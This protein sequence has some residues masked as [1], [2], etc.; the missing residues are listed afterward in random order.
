MP[1]RPPRTIHHK[2]TPSAIDNEPLAKTTSNA[3][4][5]SGSSDS[6]RDITSPPLNA[7][8]KPALPSRSAGGKIAAL[9]AGLLSSLEQKLQHGPP[10]APPKEKTEEEQDKEQEEKTP[11]Q[12]ARKGRARGPARRK[13]A[14]SP[15]APVIEEEKTFESKGV[16]TKLSITQP[17][18][19]WQIGGEGDGRIQIIHAFQEQERE[20]SEAEPEAKAFD[21]ATFEREA[22]N[23]VAAAGP[24]TA[25]T[26]LLEKSE[27]S[28]SFI[29][30]AVSSEDAI[31]SVEKVVSPQEQISSKTEALSE[32]DKHLEEKLP[33]PEET[34]ELG[35]IPNDAEFS[36]LEEKETEPEL[37]GGKEPMP[38]ERIMSLVVDDA[39]SLPK[40]AE[41]API[42][43]QSLTEGEKRFSQDPASTSQPEDTVTRTVS[44]KADDLESAEREGLLRT[45]TEE[46]VVQAEH[47]AHA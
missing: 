47:H 3:S 5:E 33:A 39:S 22:E 40:T 14:V 27:E 43:Q 38:V 13:P 6:T 11:L 9:K 17:W 19:V 30:P 25:P 21:Q 7:K 15:A 16:Q 23:A 44:T 2:Q 32:E 36:K 34:V 20:I 42:D 29:P 12:D 35:S 28:A 26:P 45:D 46:T 31:S 24:A 1:A 18:G 41:A 8:P 10:A 37:P 4:I